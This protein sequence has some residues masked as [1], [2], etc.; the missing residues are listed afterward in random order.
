MFTK[1]AFASNVPAHSR[2]LKNKGVSPCHGT[3]KSH[4]RLTADSDQS[5]G[6]FL[7]SAPAFSLILMKVPFWKWRISGNGPATA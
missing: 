4:G 7:G 3:K 1:M 5:R 2:N 6:H